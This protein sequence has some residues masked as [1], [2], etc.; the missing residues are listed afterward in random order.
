MGGGP[1][2]A[3]WDAVAR[4]R[5]AVPSASREVVA[6]WSGMR[7]SVGADLP[8]MGLAAGDRPAADV[9]VLASVAAAA[10]FELARRMHA[11][12]VSGSLPFPGPGQMLA[13]RTWSIRSARRLAR[14]GALAADHESVA[15]AWAS[16]AITSE[17]VDAVAARADRFSPSELAAVVAEI[18]PYWGRWSPRAI[19]RFA[20]EA[21]RL[22]HPPGDDPD[23]D[24]AAAYASRGL[25]FALTRDAVVI[26]GE[27]PRLEGELVVAALDAYAEK[28]R[29]AADDV[30][31]SARRADALVE[32]VSTAH[33]AGVLPTR[34]GLPVSVSVTLDRT[35]L[36]DPLWSTSRGHQLTPSEERFVGCDAAVTPVVIDRTPAPPIVCPDT[37][38]ELLA[39]PGAGDPAGAT[40]TG[41]SGGPARAAGAGGATV[42]RSGRPAGSPDDEGVEVRQ[43]L[44]ALAV[45]LMGRQVPLA[46][47][48]AERTATPAQRRAL[49]V[50]DRG[51]VIPGCGVVAEACQVHHLT[52][53]ARGGSSDPDNLVL[54]CWAH[55]RQVDLRMWS[56]EPDSSGGV[57]LPAP[58][59]GNERR[60]AWPGNNGSPWVVRAQPRTRWRT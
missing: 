58:E 14:T 49:A 48:R 25:S 29:T 30:L 24:E 11:A 43:R 39:W 18:E 8:S 40:T 35:S 26:S 9:E 12:S 52:E 20:E 10:E 45:A 17:H 7:G 32:L 37:V 57:G 51:C 27:L 15:T 34:G 38:D 53:W 22:L 56:I 1:R 13:A 28:L 19:A 4:T 31:A 42:R 3:Q 16:G 60:S 23:A 54:L 44:G 2:A 55:H 41:G 6:A 36:G 47:G 33:A 5:A 50:R 21:D 59:H 46:V